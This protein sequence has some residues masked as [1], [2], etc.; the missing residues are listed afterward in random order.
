MSFLDSVK[1]K[2]SNLKPDAR[3]KVVFAIII[4]SGLTVAYGGH[5]LSSDK[6]VVVKTKETGAQPLSVNN[7]LLE[8]SM[9]S[10]AAEQKLK[11]EELEKQMKAMADGKTVVA[12]AT[13][14]KSPLGTPAI[15]PKP[16]NTKSMA[17]PP[18]FNMPPANVLP[19]P[20]PLGSANT[21][22]GPHGARAAGGRGEDADGITEMGGDIEI[23]SAERA[24][25]KDGGADKDKK[26]VEDQLYLPSG[27]F[28][29]ATLLH[30]L[31]A[32]TT[33]AAKGEPMPV[34]IR[35]KT[36]SQLPNRVKSNLKGCFVIASAVGKLS[37]QRAHLRLTNISCITKGG[38]A[39]IDQ[40]IQGYVADADGFIGLK[41]RVVSKMG[42]AIARGF[43]AG[44][45]G[46]IGSGLSASSQNTSYGPLGATS[47]PVVDPVK[48]G[49]AG[50][51]QGLS[52][53]TK[54]IQKFYMELAKE[55]L[56]VV[57][58]LP[59]KK[60]TMIL[61]KGVKLDVKPLKKAE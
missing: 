53:A 22:M 61:T 42:D 32:P 27:S 52:D 40:K 2:F 3:R 44:F 51:G 56:P 49:L 37:D 20:V 38:E 50:M 58:I 16:V 25:A 43:L 55:T 15:P 14:G 17:P 36:L 31:Y 48:I 39:V 23:V 54:Q 28:T 45:F 26:K 11:I 5:L 34:L 60:I 33:S 1:T 8:S 30:G 21:K 57:E 35:I 7:K 41:G 29:E 59:Q 19:P 9:T 24:S 18:A 13:G 46:G 6:K 12:D 47:M 10:Q 4:L